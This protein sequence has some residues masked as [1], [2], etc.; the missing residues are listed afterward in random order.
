MIYEHSCLPG[1]P[2]KDM[3]IRIPRGRPTNLSPTLDLEAAQSPGSS[4]SQQ[5]SRSSLAY[6]GTWRETGPSVPLEAG[7]QP[8]SRL[9]TLKWTHDTILAVL[10]CVLR[11]VLPARDISSGLAGATP[12]RE[13]GNRPAISGQTVD[14]AAD[15]CPSTRLTTVLEAAAPARGLHR[16]RAHPSTWPQAYCL[17]TLLCTQQLPHNTSS[18]SAT[19]VLFFSQFS[20]R[21][22]SVLVKCEIARKNKRCD[23]KHQT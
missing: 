13:P 17:Q 7:L 2:T 8:Q 16:I 19:L 18:L 1:D 10:S 4:P 23:R 22:K 20:L 9:W 5:W 21:S 14:P 15:S 12:S 6:P 3:P 11:P